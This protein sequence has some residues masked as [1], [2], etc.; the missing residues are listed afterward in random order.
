VIWTNT[1]SVDEH[2]TTS[3]EGYWGSPLLE[4]RQTYAL[5]FPVTGIFP[6]V[7]SFYEEAGM[8]GTIQAN[9][10]PLLISAAPLPDHDFQFTITN[11]VAGE[12]NLIQASTNLLVWTGIYTNV[13]SGSSYTYVDAKAAVSRCIFY[14]TLTLP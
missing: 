3:T 9:P 7:D 8:T 12:T 14:R 5:T 4:Y 2:D 11:L 6:Y 1:D 13:A 10:V